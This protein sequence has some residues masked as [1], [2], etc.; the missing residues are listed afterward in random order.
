M[1]Q[2]RDI[3]LAAFFVWIVIDGI[4]VFRRR[5]GAAEN[6]DRSSL[7]VLMM[8]NVLAWILAFWLAFAYPGTIRPPQLQ[9]AGL[10][11]MAAG[12]AIRSVAIAQLGR[13]HTPNVAVLADH[14]VMDRGLYHVVRHPSYLGALIAFLGLGLALGNWFSVIAL[15]LMTVIVYSYRIHEEETALQAA[16]GARYADYCHRTKRLIPGVY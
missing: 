6:R 4:V 12:I 14:E 10:L 15:V 2:I 1:T 8:G 13:F 9:L 16:L 5:T 11:V 7:Q 3:A